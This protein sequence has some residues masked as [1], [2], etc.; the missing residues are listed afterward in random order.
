[1]VCQRLKL[2]EKHTA[3]I[4]VRLC[5]SSEK[6]EMLMP[7]SSPENTYSDHSEGPEI[8]LSPAVSGKDEIFSLE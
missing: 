3:V 7:F 4:Y 5:S 8:Q 2:H 1:M 6:R